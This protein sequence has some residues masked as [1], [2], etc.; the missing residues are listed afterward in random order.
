MRGL[1]STLKYPVVPGRF[2][3]Q[4]RSIDGHYGSYRMVTGSI[5]AYGC[6]RASRDLEVSMKMPGVMLRGVF[7]L[8]VLEVALA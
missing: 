8:K 7:H 1:K 5:F 2:L 4:V 3:S 6:I